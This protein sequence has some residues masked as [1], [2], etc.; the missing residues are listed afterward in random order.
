[1]LAMNNINI[2]ILNNEID[3]ISHENYSFDL[4]GVNDSRHIDLQSLYEKNTNNSILLA[5]QPKS[6]SLIDTL[7]KTKI[8][9]CGHTHG[10]QILPFGALM[11]KRQNQPYLKGLHK[12]RSSDIYVNSGA[13]H[14]IVPWRFLTKGEITNLVINNRVRNSS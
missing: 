7:T 9:L 4:I 5:H 8:M 6:I 1:M 2:K 10:G 3:S 13:G 11:L 14:T 12:Y